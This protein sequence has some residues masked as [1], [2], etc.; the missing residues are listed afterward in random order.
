MY[1]QL[2]YATPF[3]NLKYKSLTSQL[4]GKFHQPIDL[5]DTDL[6]VDKLTNTCNTA[7]SDTATE[8]L[9]KCQSKKKPWMTDAILALCDERRKLKNHTQLPSI[10]NAT[11]S[12]L[13]VLH[14]RYSEIIIKYLVRKHR[15]LC[16]Q[17]GPNSSILSHL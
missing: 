16:T 9:E 3:N 13:M 11:P 4:G 5:M 8:V 15:L 7:I 6:D 10:V 17:L 14:L 12:L 1:Y 2:K